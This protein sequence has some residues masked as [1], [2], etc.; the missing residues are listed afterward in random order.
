[1]NLNLL[2]DL[3]LFRFERDEWD[4]IEAYYMMY[5][6]RIFVGILLWTYII[7]SFLFFQIYT[8]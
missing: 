2:K 5:A 3:I 4:S 6:C 8:V 1:M 7:L